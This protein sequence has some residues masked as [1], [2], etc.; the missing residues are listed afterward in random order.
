VLKQGHRDQ[1]EMLVLSDADEQ[2]LLTVSFKG[3]VKIHSLQI[4]APADGRA[5]KTVK[6]FANKANLDFSDVES[7]AADQTFE[8]TPETFGQ[9]LELKFVKFQNVDRLTVFF[10]DNQGDEEATA[11][12]GVRLWGASLAGTNMSDFK[13]VAGEKGEGE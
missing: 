13:R 7:M 4:D 5:P 9:R 8:F 1:A 2:L 11:I 12:S 3:K 10:A 6:L